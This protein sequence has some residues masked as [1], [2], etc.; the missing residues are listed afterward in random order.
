MR[1]RGTAGLLLVAFLIWANSAAWWETRSFHQ[2]DLSTETAGHQNS[3]ERGHILCHA[4]MRSE[5]AIQASG[6]PGMPCDSQHICCFTQT[7]H[8]PLA[9]STNSERLR[10]G[11]FNADIA[12]AALNSG[13]SAWRSDSEIA[14]SVPAYLQ[15]S[16]ILR[17]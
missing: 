17:V 11:L 13:K 8:I 5:V 4:G 9:S 12:F 7:P 16:M 1:S 3:L 10:A 15:L 2:S 6:T 14:E